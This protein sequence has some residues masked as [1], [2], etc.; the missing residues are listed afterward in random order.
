MKCEE[1]GTTLRVV[2]ESYTT[3]TC[4]DCGRHNEVGSLKIIRCRCGFVID[5]DLTGARNIMIKY[6]ST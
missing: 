5:R 6:E 1:F 4:G 2:D 3:K